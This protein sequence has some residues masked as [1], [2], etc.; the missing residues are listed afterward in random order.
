MD[1]PKKFCNLQKNIIEVL[2]YASLMLLVYFLQGSK[3]VDFLTDFQFLEMLIMASLT[4]AG[5]GTALLG[6]MVIIP[7]P[8]G[9]KDESIFRFR[10]VLF[11]RLKR[12]ALYFFICSFIGFIV[13]IL[14]PTYYS[15]ISPLS[16]LA[17]LLFFN[18][19]AHL[20]YVCLKMEQV[21][22]RRGDS[23]R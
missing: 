10:R 8:T 7:T 19:W 18:G 2:I 4:I 9:I 15:D 5:V 22:L 3:V 13:Y 1:V 16:C 6:F 11:S 20:F 12:G 21:S 23:G 14:S 17:V